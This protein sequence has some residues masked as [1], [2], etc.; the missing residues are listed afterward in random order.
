M[1]LRA[2]RKLRGSRPS[3]ERGKLDWIAW[4]REVPAVGATGPPSLRSPSGA[5]C[6][7][8]ARGVR[9]HWRTRTPIAA[10]CVSFRYVAADP[11]QPRQVIFDV[12]PCDSQLPEMPGPSMPALCS[13]LCH[14]TSGSDLRAKT[15]RPLHA[16]HLSPSVRTPRRRKPV[17]QPVERQ[18][19]LVDVLSS[20]RPARTSLQ[21]PDGVRSSSTSAPTSTQYW[22][23]SVN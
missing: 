14:C 3:M 19:R 23:G 6:G 1:T 4:R 5:A 20:N 12:L 11:A 15:P 22:P 8:R 18:R 17:K 9:P 7:Q 10:Q 16:V 21:Y 2:E 13:S